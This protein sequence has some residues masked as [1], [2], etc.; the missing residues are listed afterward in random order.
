MTTETPQRVSLN[1]IQNDQQ[2]RLLTGVLEAMSDPLY[3]IDVESYR[4]VLANKAARELGIGE[5]QTCYALTHRRDTPCDGRNHP[6]PLKMMQQNNQ[7]AVVEHIHY[8]KDGRLRNMEVHAFP[9][10]DDDGR[11][12]HMVEYS[13]DITA[14]RQAE[15]TARKLSRVVE[16]TPVAVV[17]TDLNG[18]IE[19]VNPTFSHLTGYEPD[20]VIGQNPRILKSGIHPPE[21]YDELWQTISTGEIWRGEWCNRKKDGD[22]YWEE[23]AFAPILDEAG[24]VTHYLKVSEDITGRKRRRETLRHYMQELETQN[25][26]LDAFAHTVAHDLKTPINVIVGY[27]EV[28]KSRADDFTPEQRWQFLDKVVWNGRKM[29][30]IINSLLLLATIRSQEGVTLYPVEMDQVVATVLERLARMIE[31]KQAR[32][33]VA[34]EWPLALGYAPWIEE[35]WMNYLSNALKYGGE[36][37]VIEMGATTLADGRIRFWLRDNGQGLSYEARQRIFLP[38]E[39]MH[40]A[41]IEGQGLGLSIVK[42]IADRLGGQVGVASEVGQGSTFY[43]EL[44]TM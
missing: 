34:E 35:I 15:E 14:R 11:L 18:T 12:T 5:A 20:E 40:Q 19:Y 33:T 1:V 2:A 37:P 24:Q 32:I 28:L 44:P 13:I 10:L 27:A 38:F 6:C 30:D 17:I 8:D 23:A 36:P 3:V 41:H 42:R 16:Q 25:A 7:S 26:E 29:N 22:L 31:E 43:L 21:L 4:I 9:L 39:R